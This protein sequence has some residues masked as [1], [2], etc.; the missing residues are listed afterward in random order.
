MIKDYL[1]LRTDLQYVEIDEGN[2][3]EYAVFIIVFLYHFI[4]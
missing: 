3:D 2:V 4:Y 1:L